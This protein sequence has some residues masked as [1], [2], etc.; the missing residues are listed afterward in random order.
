MRKVVPID[1]DIAPIMAKIQEVLAALEKTRAV[2]GNISVGAQG[3]PGSGLSGTFTTASAPGVNPA[4]GSVGM[5]G[6]SAFIGVPP[7]VSPGGP[8]A[9]VFGTGF[10]MGSMGQTPNMG[11]NYFGGMGIP[12]APQNVSV[13]PNSNY[14]FQSPFGAAPDQ[15]SWGDDQQFGWVRGHFRRYPGQG[16]GG[17]ASAAQAF[18]AATGP[19]GGSDS[20]FADAG[21]GFVPPTSRYTGVGAGGSAWGG[22]PF[23]AAPSGGG[24]MGG[25]FGGG[26]AGGGGGTGGG[27]GGVSPPTVTPGSGADG[28]GAQTAF[29]QY[30]SFRTY[31]EL[32]RG[33]ADVAN[34]YTQFQISGQPNPLG[35]GVTAGNLIGGGIGAG[36]AMAGVGA[37]TAGLVGLVAAPLISSGINAL[38]AQDIQRQRVTTDFSVYAGETGQSASG[39]A[40]NASS[41]AAQFNTQIFQSGLARAHQ[42]GWERGGSPF[43][44]LGNAVAGIGMYASAYINA[45]RRNIGWY[46]DVD[47]QTTQGAA[48]IEQAVGGASLANGQLLSPDALA[49]AS[50]PFID[51][52]MIGVAQAQ[53]Y[54]GVK[55]ALPSVGGNVFSLALKAGVGPTLQMMRADGMLP[56]YASGALGAANPVLGSMLDLALGT[57]DGSALAGAAAGYQRGQYNIRGA[58]A[59][60]SGAGSEYDRSAYSGRSTFARRPEFERAQSAL[61]ANYDLISTEYAT[62]QAGPGRDSAEA[63]ELYA[64]GQS[65]LT[66]IDRNQALRSEGIVGDISAA[67]RANLASANYSSTLASLFGTQADLRQGGVMEAATITDTAN[68][69]QGS[70]GLPGQSPQVMANI[71][72]DVNTMRSQAL[73]ARVRG[74]DAGQQRRFL[75]QDTTLSVFQAD[76]T[77]AELYGS[78]AELGRTAGQAVGAQNFIASDAARQSLDMGASEE[79]RARDTFRSASARQQSLNLRARSRDT[80]LSRLSGRAAIAESD[81][82]NA[83]AG[84]QYG[85]ENDVARAGGGLLSALG[86][87]RGTLMDQIRQG[88][89]TVEQDLRTRQR[90]SALEG[91]ITRV[92]IST[93]DTIIGRIETGAGLANQAAGNELNRAM[94]IGTGN[95]VRGA[96]GGLLQALGSEAGR[97]NDQV[98]QGNLTF[99]QRARI[100][101]RLQTIS[102][103]AF[104]TGQDAID[105]GFARDD[106]A[107]FGIQSTRN[108][109]QRALAQLMPFGGGNRLSANVNTI[110]TDEA[111]IGVLQQRYAALQQSGNLSPERAF[112]LEQEGGRLQIERGQGIAA[113]SEGMENYLPALS[114][115]RG[116][117]YSMYDS[118]QLAALRVN[119][120]GSNIRSY[121]GIN[122]AQSARQA[123]A[124][125]EMSGGGISGG[126]HSLTQGINN[127]GAS[128]ILLTQIRDILQRMGSAATGSTQ[129]ISETAGQA[130][131]MIGQRDV[132]AGYDGRRF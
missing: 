132:G 32:A 123:H 113:L 44:M 26:G 82:S 63:K 110:R 37:A 9:G 58:E 11:P 36:L 8:T 90:V 99:D 31:R 118:L 70:I 96:A 15:P 48:S 71:Q 67:G 43:D 130:H 89:M 49:R 27:G 19:Q 40:S 103:Q 30:M 101:D 12:G 74:V 97:L 112:Q 84:A 95:D 98:A 87:E 4:S 55:S 100:Q 115:G 45:G 57:D 17:G 121:G 61:R 14:N 16:T 28:G 125:D 104:N 23:N 10:G 6:G 114:S 60:A 24:P 1:G 39:L 5:S 91:D 41:L 18:T 126:P 106:M 102:Q 131:G 2:A 73:Q 80:L 20:G 77:G 68:R 42:V 21:G 76:I 124:W 54:G 56:S 105:Q 51:Q 52:G 66:Q 85:D 79:Q 53:Q 47:Q 62:M 13:P 3:V 22:G 65:T 7:T 50:Q 29:G 38:Q 128:D 108:A 86:A 35:F 81:A 119:R 34:D 25:G 122:G 75:G 83:L 109:T 93:R 78:D 69:L 33:A 117:N 46:S 120:T 111:Q 116:A 107:G 94:R 127:G 129:R 92:G 59:L 72:A 64:R 88:G